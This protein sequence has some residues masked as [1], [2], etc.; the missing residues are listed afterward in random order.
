MKNHP[1]TANLD[2]FDNEFS[3]MNPYDFAGL[4]NL[5]EASHSI[6][7][8]SYFYHPH[9]TL[10]LHFFLAGYLIYQEFVALIDLAKNRGLNRN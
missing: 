3:N 6:F 1:P 10:S 5:I 8:L 2:D 4:F 9:H 7:K